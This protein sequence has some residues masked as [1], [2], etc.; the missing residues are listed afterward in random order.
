M[1][2]NARKRARPIFSCLECKRK[3]LKCDR[4]Q[5]CHQCS[6]LGRST[7]CRYAEEDEREELS[8]SNLNDSVSSIADLA[9]RVAALEEWKAEAG[10]AGAPNGNIASVSSS[11]FASHAKYPSSLHRKGDSVRFRSRHHWSVLQAEVSLLL[12]HFHDRQRLQLALRTTLL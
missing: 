1:S 10:R 8:D 9:K 5:P 2:L 7:R 3:K 12:L 4:Q 6:R 11:S